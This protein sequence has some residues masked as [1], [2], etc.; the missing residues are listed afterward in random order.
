MSVITRS[1]PWRVYEPA[2][3]LGHTR[4][5]VWESVLVTSSGSGLAPISSLENTETKV[6]IDKK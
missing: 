1:S 2:K 4:A 5:G 6:L 3:H